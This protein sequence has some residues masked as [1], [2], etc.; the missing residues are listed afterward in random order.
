M[1]RRAALAAES[2]TT[3]GK[4]LKKSRVHLTTPEKNGESKGTMGE[5]P[6]VRLFE[7]QAR[8]S[9]KRHSF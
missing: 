8:F 9:Q 5:L 3:P 6:K 2:Q 1:S 7:N 4:L